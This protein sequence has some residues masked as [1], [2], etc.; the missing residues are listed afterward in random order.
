MADAPKKRSG[1]ER[2]DKLLLAQG[3]AP[4][5]EKAAALIM[6]NQVSHQGQGVSKAGELLP[7]DTVLEVAAAPIP[8]VSR[9]GLKLA[10]GLQSFA[11]NPTGRV[12]LDIGASTGGFTDCLLQ[13]GAAKVYAV[14]VGYGQLAW[15]LRQNLKVVNLERENFRYLARE[16]IDSTIDLAVCDVS[17]ISL[18]HIFARLPEFLA[19]EGQVVAL[20]KPQ[21]EA[22]KGKVGKNGVVKSPELH[23]EVLS[24]IQQEGARASLWLTALTPSPLRGPKGNV[25][26]L[27][28]WQLTRP[29]AEEGLVGVAEIVRVVALAHEQFM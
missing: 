2:A 8:F 21:F 7:E 16:K 12:C 17:F 10:H 13:H 24:N 26:F 19:P 1:K 18:K 20:V 25:E 27:S 22:G 6:S 9:G 23:R 11:L 15:S 5:R 3:L 29:L 4:S 14:D 28:C